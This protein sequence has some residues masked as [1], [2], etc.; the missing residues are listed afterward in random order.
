[1]S[2]EEV[3]AGCIRAVFKL[4]HRS[5]SITF[6]KFTVLSI[7]SSLYSCWVELSFDAAN[8]KATGS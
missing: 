8:P 3:V 1:M 7:S 2:E 6:S 4:L 5:L